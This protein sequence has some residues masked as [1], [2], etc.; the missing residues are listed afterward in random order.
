MNITDQTI[1]SF[2][3]QEN[4]ILAEMAFEAMKTQQLFIPTELLDQMIGKHTDNPHQYARLKQKILAL[5]ILYVDY[6]PTDPE[7]LGYHFIQLL[8]YEYYAA[9]HIALA[10]ADENPKSKIHQSIL[11]FTA[12]EKYNPHYHTVWCLVAGI[13]ASKHPKYVERFFIQLMQPPHELVPIN[14]WPLW[15]RCLDEARLPSWRYEK[16]MLAALNG[17]LQ[18]WLPFRIEFEHRN[19]EKRTI[20]PIWNKFFQMSPYVLGQAPLIESLSNK[21]KQETEGGLYQH[22]EAVTF[23]AESSFCLFLPPTTVA[24]LLDVL[25]LMSPVT[26]EQDA[27]VVL[28]RLPLPA[29]LSRQRFTL[30]IKV[31]EKWFLD[32]DKSAWFSRSALPHL[33]LS[34]QQIQ[35]YTEVLFRLLNKALASSESDVVKMTYD[36]VDTFFCLPLS[37][38]QLMRCYEML[39]K[40]SE[41]NPDFCELTKAKLWL[42][43]VPQ[44]SFEQILKDIPILIKILANSYYSHQSDDKRELVAK[45]M[46]ILQNQCTSTQISQCV[47]CL[48]KI[49]TQPESHVYVPKEVMSVLTQFIL[50]LTR[51]EVSLYCLEIMIDLFKSNNNNVIELA[52][53]ALANLIGK[54]HAKEADR[55]F[56]ILME[57]IEQDYHVAVTAKAISIQLSYLSITQ[58]TRYIDSLIGTMTIIYD[59]PEKIR[60]KNLDNT[61]VEI[62]DNLIPSL[63]RIQTIAYV[64]I[65]VEVIHL[66]NDQG[67]HDYATKALGVCRTFP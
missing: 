22:D 52:A 21:L 2:F 4:L 50:Q 45:F 59:E 51:P 49:A 55:C 36:L 13:L 14:S 42:R 30:S 12:R 67:V 54:L 60:M 58:V 1:E 25:V 47:D 35:A 46:Q 66:S 53:A 33:L 38:V 44:L 27:S 29:S 57:A 41:K 11:H 40:I 64:G 10:Y 9:C 63:S 17:W 16:E 6:C 31:L 37:P 24:E 23:L 7:K 19:A 62:M 18:F 56:N 20:I 39:T 3:E 48:S 15:L 5:G 32:K 65:F 61:I 8:F 28:M 43:V 26:Y 34:P